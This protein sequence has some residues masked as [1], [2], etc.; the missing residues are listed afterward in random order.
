MIHKT[1]VTV[2]IYK[3]N[4]FN[5][6]NRFKMQDGNQEA[7]VIEQNKQFA[8]VKQDGMWKSM[9]NHPFLSNWPQIIVLINNL[10]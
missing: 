2:S 4:G 9:S 8:H 5:F 10:R 3:I 1:I 6:E 7:L